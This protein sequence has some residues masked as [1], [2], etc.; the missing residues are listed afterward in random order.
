[1]PPRK[2]CSAR[3]Q[4]RK[5]HHWS[6]ATTVGR[7]WYTMEE[8][9]RRNRVCSTRSVVCYT[10]RTWKQS[11]RWHGRT[12]RLS[13]T[14]LLTERDHSIAIA[15]YPRGWSAIAFYSLLEHFIRQTEKN[16]LK[17]LRVEKYFIYLQRV[18]H[19]TMNLFTVFC[20]TQGLV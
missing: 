2:W 19:I 11:I 6:N 20:L 3:N 1:M 9:V 17:T 13:Y 5:L 12:E 18:S 4:K 15:D 10:Q 16:K 7:C 8:A 14:G